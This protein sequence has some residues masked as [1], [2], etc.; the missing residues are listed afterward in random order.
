MPM[1]HSTLGHG[2][3][4]KMYFLLL[5]R[6]IQDGPALRALTLSRFALHLLETLSVEEFNAEFNHLY[7]ARMPADSVIKADLEYISHHWSDLSY[8]P[9]EESYAYGH[10]FNMMA[11][12][13]ALTLGAQLARKLGDGGAADWYE[14]QLPEI[15]EFLDEFWDRSDG[16][17][18]SSIKHQR[19]VEWKT[20]QL[21]TAVLIAVLFSNSTDD[22]DPYP[23]C[24][25]SLLNAISLAVSDKVM[26][27]FVALNAS[28]AKTYPINDGEF[29]PCFG[30]YQEDIYDGVAFS[31]GNPWFLTTLAGAEYLYSIIPYILSPVSNRGFNLSH[32]FF[33]AYLIPPDVVTF[34]EILGLETEREELACAVA[35]DADERLTW[36]QKYRSGLDLSEQF[37]RFKGEQIGAKKLTW[38]YEA[39]LK[40]ADRRRALEPWI[41]GCY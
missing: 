24:T 20:S 7:E 31:G 15:N 38:S 9:W 1:V 18:K 13:E 41:D 40:T 19:G 17:I 8:D 33:K 21:D 3:D 25:L 10:L 28:F 14:L 26:S 6:S 29:S 36:V 30:R 32:D 39:F 23:I 16:W 2:H 11:A 22:T 37:S 5:Q 12:R 4:L 34:Q 27:T 35:K